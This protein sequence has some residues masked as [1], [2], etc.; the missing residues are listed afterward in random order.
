MAPATS[1]G[2]KRLRPAAV[3]RVDAAVHEPAQGAAHP[4]IRERL[5]R[6]VAEPA[7]KGD[8]QMA[9]DR[10]DAPQ[11]ALEAPSARGGLRSPLAL[12]LPRSP[13][14]GN[15]LQSGTA[16]LLPA[17][18]RRDLSR[19][20]QAHAGGSSRPGAP[21]AWPARGAALRRALVAS[22]APVWGRPPKRRHLR[23][24]AQGPLHQA[25]VELDAADREAAAVDGLAQAQ[26]TGQRP[27]LAPQQ[28]QVT[29]QAEPVAPIPAVPPAATHLP[30][31]AAEDGQRAHP[32]A[33]AAALLLRC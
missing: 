14:A 33:T 28:H 15:E 10:Q 31:A 5:A 6:R 23:I 2:C 4:Q 12:L 25:P 20:R 8:P 13:G 18:L 21:A 19:A 22:P 17:G 7:G 32:F 1:I 11:L 9:W 3:L 29:G 16:P 27:R 30:A 24:D 26:G